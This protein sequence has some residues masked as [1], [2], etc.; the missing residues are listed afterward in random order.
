MA[1]L[2]RSVTRRA[3]SAASVAT[4]RACR[5]GFLQRDLERELAAAGC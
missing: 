2:S 3:C 5:P 1:A 4:L